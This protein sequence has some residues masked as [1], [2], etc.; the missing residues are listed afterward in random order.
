MPCGGAGSPARFATPCES[1][2]TARPRAVSSRDF[3]FFH[4]FPS[5]LQ[6]SRPK[7]DMDSAADEFSP[8]RRGGAE[9]NPWCSGLRF[10]VDQGWSTRQISESRIQPMQSVQAD[11]IFEPGISACRIFSRAFT[12]LQLFLWLRPRPSGGTPRRGGFRGKMNK[13]DR[14]P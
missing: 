8:Q 10:N 12:S 7:P 3:E 13:R 5:D 2:E 1:L 11:P 4:S 14:R 6:I 9:K